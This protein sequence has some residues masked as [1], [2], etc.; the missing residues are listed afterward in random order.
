MKTF[1]NKLKNVLRRY[2]ENPNALKVAG[3]FLR[4]FVF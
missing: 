3:K 2:F 1:V 4:K